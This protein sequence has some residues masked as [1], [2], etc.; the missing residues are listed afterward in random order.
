MRE[1]VKEIASSVCPAV[2]FENEKALIDDQILESLDIV[3][4]VSEL[5][6]E[7]EIQLDV[8]DLA[9]ENFNSLDAIAEL[10]ESYL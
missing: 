6:Y 4:I 7:F 5:M 9:P 1:R 10:V 2:D 8:E 3:S